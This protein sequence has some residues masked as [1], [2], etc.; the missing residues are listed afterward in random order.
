MEGEMAAASF[1]SRFVTRIDTA[2]ATLTAN[3]ATLTV[4]FGLVINA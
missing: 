2:W 1:C 3:H 4:T